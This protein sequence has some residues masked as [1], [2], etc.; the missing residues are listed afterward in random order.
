MHPRHLAV[1]T[2][3]DYISILFIYTSPRTLFRLGQVNRLLKAAVERYMR[4]VYNIGRHLLRFFSSP[5]GF[6]KLQSESGT[7]I[8]GSNALQFLLRQTYPLS[9]LDLYV[10]LDNHERITEWLSN[11]EGYQLTS[12]P[13]QHPFYYDSREIFSVLQF[14]KERRDGSVAC[15]QVIVC[16]RCPLHAILS[17]HSSM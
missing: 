4:R 7:I 2:D 10:H 13:P 9:D 11:V 6:R 17:F 3:D 12:S 8:S 14:E 16:S 5:A 1:L 15:V